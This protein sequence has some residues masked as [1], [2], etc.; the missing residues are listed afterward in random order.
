[1]VKKELVPV[2]EGYWDFV[3]TLCPTVLFGRAGG[4]SRRRS[5]QRQDHLLGLGCA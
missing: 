3:L 5:G 2:C 4:L 1:M